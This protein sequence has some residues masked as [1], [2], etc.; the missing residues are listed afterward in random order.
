MSR[1][2][3][4]RAGRSPGR[5]RASR[6]LCE[7]WT[8]RSDGSRSK[9]KHSK[10]AAWDAW[11]SRRGGTRA[12]E[13]GRVAGA[14]TVPASAR[15]RP[16]S[17]PRQPTR[18]RKTPREVTALPRGLGLPRGH[19]G[20]HARGTPTDVQS[21]MLR[22]CVTRP[23]SPYRPS[24]PGICPSAFGPRPAVARAHAMVPI[25]HAARLVPRHLDADARG[26]P[27]FTTPPRGTPAATPS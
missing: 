21:M 12:K 25:E 8:L 22:S 14:K 6:D 15:K 11:W 4:R 19:H 10:V 16:T 23:L 1:G 24:V 3:G 20:Q 17:T 9:T 2:T 13:A 5:L 26:T 18:G 27:A 7:F